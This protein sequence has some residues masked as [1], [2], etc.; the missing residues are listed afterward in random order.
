MM[1]GIRNLIPVFGDQLD[2]ISPSLQRVSKE[3]DVFIMAEVESEITRFPNHKHRV[4]LFLSAMRHYRDFLRKQGYHVKYQS[5]GD[6]H[7]SCSLSTF[8]TK[9]IETLKPEKLILTEPGR[10]DLE[11][12][13]E[14]IAQ[15]NHISFELRP[16]S[17][18]LCSRSDFKEWTIGR[19]I[20][21]MEYFYREMRKRYGYLMQGD[22]PE[23]GIWNF[24]KS[25]RDTFPATGPGAIRMSASFQPDEITREVIRLVEKHFPS[26][27]GSGVNFDWPVTFAEAQAAAEDFIQYHLANFGSYQDAMWTDKPFLYHSRLSA[28]LNL[29]LLNPKTLIQDVLQIY[30]SRKI[31]LNSIEG[32]IRQI[33]G[34]R[35]F[36]RGVY[37]LYMPDYINFNKM[38]ASKNLPDF[39]WTGDTHMFCLQQVVKQLL[40]H[41]YAHHIQRLMVTG[42]FSLLYGISPK[43]IHDWYMAMYVDS[44]E[45]VTLPN[46]IGM[47]QHAD[48]GV[49]GTKPYIASGK[50]INRMS[51]YCE[52]C[53]YNPDKSVGEDACPFTTLY[54]SYLIKNQALLK[55][56][57]RMTFQINNMARKS[58]DEVKSNPETSGF[59]EKKD[60]GKDHLRFIMQLNLT[61]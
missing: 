22:K 1:S 18:F 14:T 41:A 10:Y 47:S 50:Y 54:W 9:Q 8:I 30:E 16:D 46:T 56:N 59:C 51:N 57:R 6:P 53:P 35:E 39:Y 7:V 20:L 4:I 49:I 5:I 11:K 21:V 45:W 19:K 37:W 44:V 12:E 28:P 23:G 25:N 27:P 31:P 2:P 17:T 55:N 52:K 61:D 43:E 13:C 26:L 42:L 33:S 34:W 40:K 3:Q 60:P 32:F 58:T 29:K 38:A 24:D 48:G 36:I 15:K